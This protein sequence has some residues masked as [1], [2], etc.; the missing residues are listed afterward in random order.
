MESVSLSN[1]WFTNRLWQIAFNVSAR[2]YKTFHNP[3]KDLM[4][5]PL[6]FIILD[7]IYF[8]LPIV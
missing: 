4:R 6:F 8:S 7:K 1:Q 5:D 3:M 2:T